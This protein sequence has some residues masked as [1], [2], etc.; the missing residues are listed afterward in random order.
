MV[1]D[2][3]A[4]VLIEK[5]GEF[6]HGFTYSGHPVCCAVAAANIRIL[7]D[8]RIIERAKEET[9][10]YLQA[11]IRE[12]ENHPLVGE[13]RGVGMF[14]ALQLVQDK[15]SRRLFAPQGDVGSMCKDHCMENDLIMRAV[16]DSVI[17][18]PPLII[19]KAEI[20]ELMEKAGRALDLTARDLGIS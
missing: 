12:L 3:M 17:L 1:S 7:R 4:D 2:A 20:D 16:G 13:V 8:E 19:T 15:S 10:P 11:R 9:M 18:S 5:G 14:G 6:Q